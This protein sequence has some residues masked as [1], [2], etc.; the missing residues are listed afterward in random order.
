MSTAAPHTFCATSV[1][2]LRAY[3]KSTNFRTISLD[4]G[5]REEYP[6]LI[7]NEVGSKSERR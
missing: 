4:L 1:Q 7:D 3:F 5:R 2:A 6:Y